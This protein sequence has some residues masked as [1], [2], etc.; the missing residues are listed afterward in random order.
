VVKRYF[1]PSR[2]AEVIL[3]AFE[4]LAWPPFIDDPL[5]REKGR[6]SK[7][8]LQNFIRNFN[9]RINCTLLSLHG[10]GFGTGIGWDA[11]DLTPSDTI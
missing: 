11:A 6:N 4:E 8:R 9:R 10:N 3:A 7:T 2:D 5:P 1:Y